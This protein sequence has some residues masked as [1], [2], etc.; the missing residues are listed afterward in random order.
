MPKSGISKGALC[1]LFFFFFSCLH[2][3]HSASDLALVRK[4]AFKKNEFTYHNRP[5]LF[6]DKK[7]LIVKYNPVSMTFGG[8]MYFYQ[9]VISR[10]FS[11]SCLYSPSCSDFSKLSIKELGLI[12]GIFMTADRIMRCNRIAQ[13]DIHP[14]QVDEKDHKVH[15]TSAIYKM[16]K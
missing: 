11:A 16:N 1:L 14:M 8:L 9:N 12:K 3:Q 7:N 2:A 10:Q 4:Q 5:Y 13:M 6:K 15:E